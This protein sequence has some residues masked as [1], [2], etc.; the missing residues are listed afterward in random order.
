MPLPIGTVI[1]ASQMSGLQPATVP[2]PQ[3]TPSA[4]AVGTTLSADQMRRI[5]MPSQPLPN[6]PLS[7]VKDVAHGL[8]NFGSDAVEGTVANAKSAFQG[9]EGDVESG[10]QA[11]QDGASGKQNPIIAGAKTTLRAGVG[12][13][14]DLAKLILSPVTGTMEASVKNISDAVSEATPLQDLANSKPVSGALDA[15]QALTDKLGEIEKNHPDAMKSLYDSVNTALIAAGGEAAP[16]EMAQTKADVSSI[17]ESLTP[18]EPPP[19]P[20]GSSSSSG[21]SDEQVQSKIETAQTKVADAYRKSLPLTPT[22]QL[23][24]ANL[25]AKGRGSVY[26]TLA[27]YNI[28]PASEDAVGQLQTLSDKFSTAANLAKQ[29]E[30]KLFNVEDIKNNAF[31]AIDQNISSASERLA[32]KDRIN[33]EINDLKTESPN[34]FN[35]NAQGQ[36][37]ANSDIVERLRKTGNNWAQYNKLNPDSVK[38]GAGSGLA[39]AVRDQVEKE[40][41]FPDYRNLNKEWGDVLH[42]Q[43]VLEKISNSGKSFKQLGGLSGTIAR[44]VLSGMLG[45]HSA[46]I[47]G[48]ILSELGTE[49]ASKFLSNPDLMTYL[50]RKIITEYGDAEAT[51]A[52]IQKVTQQVKDYVD[53]QSNLLKL[54]A[55]D[56]GVT[57]R[58]IPLPDKGIL[59]SQA[60]IK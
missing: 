30:S 38:N 31:Q 60:N 15:V 45:F 34:S 6:D 53:T 59:Q 43:D 36:D 46:G 18:D 11:L 54:P 21:L 22:E 51:P 2:T 35:K 39:D 19:A 8:F 12:T 57:P 9:L 5:T 26:T 52:S 17:K 56:N 40:G 27:K 24:E 44:R 20:P 49:Y 1:P 25:E 50:N 37:I 29:N 47:G 14:S 10:A 55:P 13:V 7:G 23:K 58:V 16:E 48:A 3:Q 42:T 33:T 4:P 28:S 41:T 32:A